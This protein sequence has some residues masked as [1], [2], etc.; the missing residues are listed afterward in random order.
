MASDKFYLEL[1]R[2][3]DDAPLFSAEYQSELRQF[4]AKANASAQRGFAMDSVDA[5]GGALGEFIYNHGEALI[6]ALTSVVVTW[7]TCRS[8]RK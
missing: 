8:G 1:I 4:S 6:T 5:V 7:L 2:S 3:K